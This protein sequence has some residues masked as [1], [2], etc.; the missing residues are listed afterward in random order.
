MSEFA[1]EVPM[2]DMCNYIIVL[3]VIFYYWCYPFSYPL[4]VCLHFCHMFFA[5]VLSNHHTCVAQD[6][7][8]ACRTITAY[9]VGV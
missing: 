2:T 4:L 5:T 8:L 9:V 1:N 7:M 6:N 3:I